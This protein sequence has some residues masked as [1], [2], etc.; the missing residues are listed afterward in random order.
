MRRCLESRT[1]LEPLDSP[2][3]VSS[4]MEANSS[5]IANWVVGMCSVVHLLFLELYL[6]IRRTACLPLG[7]NLPLAGSTMRAKT[8]L[9]DSVTWEIVNRLLLTAPTARL[10][11]HAASNSRSEGSPLSSPAVECFPFRMAL[12][13]SRHQ[14][15]CLVIPITMRSRYAA[16]S[17][18]SSAVMSAMRL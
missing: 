13:T 15:A 9:G 1:P 3:N 18:K 6:S 14:M 10:R 17:S 12:A 11:S 2:L 7:S 16:R 4:D 5:A 8:V